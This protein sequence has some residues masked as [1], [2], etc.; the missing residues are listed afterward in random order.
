MEG[1][2]F[3]VVFVVQFPLKPEVYQ[4]DILQK[5]FEAGRQLYNTL[6]TVTMKRYKEMVKTKLY[7]RSVKEVVELT[8]QIANTKDR[9]KLKLL[10][11]EKTRI[12]KQLIS[13]REQYRISEYAFHSDMKG[14]RKHFEKNIDSHTAQKIASRLWGVYERLMYGSAEAVYYKKF[15]MMNSLEG[16][17]N[18]QGI[19][20]KDDYMYWG[21][22]RIPVVIDRSNPYEAMALENNVKYCRLV[23]KR[24]RE[25]YKHYL[26]IVFDGFAP[27]KIDKATGEFKHHIGTSDVGLD[28]GTQ[29][30]AISSESSVELLELANRVQN[31]ENEKRRMQRK[32]D[33]SRRATNPDNYNADG[34][35]KKQGSKKVAWTKSNRYLRLQGE[36]QEL[37]RKQA[38][39]RKLQHE[40]LANI[41]IMLGDNVY[42]ETMQF[43]GLQT[44]AK[45]TER[46]ESGRFK[47]KKRFGKSIANKAPAMLLAILDR[48]L[49]WHGKTLMKIN[50]YETKASQY[51][52]V[53]DSYEK[54][55]L[56][57]RWNCIDGKRVQPKFPQELAHTA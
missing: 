36:L 25:K 42:V 43:S 34:T 53:A 4:Q 16:K 51:N 32:I 11:T 35:I 2:V 56:K 22:L 52:H 23:Q 8:K 15:G 44:R 6:L 45:R 19:R 30:V 9:S 14:L 49:K 41:I 12:S 17:T 21:K 13:L 26:Q 33:R 57:E 7:R 54:K 29:T 28:I 27:P 47:R 5:S 50:T 38:A 55:D 31:I 20:F 3:V 10:G 1:G 46:A 37:Q 39:I 24:I 48:K 18:K 40:Q